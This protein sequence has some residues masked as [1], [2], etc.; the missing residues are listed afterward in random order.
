MVDIVPPHVRSRMMAGIRGAH[1]AP[2]RFLRTRLHR[3]GFRYRLHV[4]GLPGRPDLVFPSR[5]AV[6]LA[7]GCFWHGH[8]CPLF[9]WPSTRPEFWRN[10][11]EGNR[12]RDQNVLRALDQGGWRVL[13]VWECALKGPGKWHPDDLVP[14]VAHWVSHGPEGLTALRGTVHSPPTSGSAEPHD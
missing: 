4:P 5:K 2:E 13:V 1:T 3:L 11:I 8:D 10:R 6:I 9:K 14:R 7:H 12:T